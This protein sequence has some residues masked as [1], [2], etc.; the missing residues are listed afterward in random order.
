VPLG[1]IDAPGYAC[2]HLAQPHLSIV[3]VNGNVEEPAE[4][5]PRRG[6]P[7]KQLRLSVSAIRSSKECGTKVQFDDNHH[8]SMQQIKQPAVEDDRLE[9]NGD[10]FLMVFS[11]L[12]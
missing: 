6:P 4:S 5:T 8:S 3:S 7:T 2:E 1:G 12:R 11:R 10:Q 9:K